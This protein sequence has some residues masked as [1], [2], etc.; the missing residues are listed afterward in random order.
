MLTNKNNDKEKES[1]QIVT[2]LYPKCDKKYCRQS[3]TLFPIIQWPLPDWTFNGQKKK[4][5]DME[6]QLNVCPTHAVDD[7]SLYIDD[8]A[9]HKLTNALS[10]RRQPVPKRDELK[11]IYKPLEDRRYAE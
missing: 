1:K 6:I 2:P 7:H 11:V 4:R 5:A 10:I 9:W 3:G 8:E